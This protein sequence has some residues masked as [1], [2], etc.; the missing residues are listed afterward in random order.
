[1]DFVPYDSPAKLAEDAAVDKWDVAMIGADPARAACLG[2][3]Y[4]HGCSLMTPG[5]FWP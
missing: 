5:A 3:G 4:Q 1:M 2:R